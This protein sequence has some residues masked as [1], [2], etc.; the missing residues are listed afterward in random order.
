[1]TTMVVKE[2]KLKLLYLEFLWNIKQK[3]FKKSR[4]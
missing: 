3:L 2:S 4:I 1:M